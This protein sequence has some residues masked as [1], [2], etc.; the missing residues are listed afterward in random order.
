MMLVVPVLVKVRQVA[1]RLGL[2]PFLAYILSAK[3]GK[4]PRSRA[5]SSVA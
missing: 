2:A 1:F 5:S 3:A 4:A